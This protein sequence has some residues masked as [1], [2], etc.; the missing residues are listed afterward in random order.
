MSRSFISA[1]TPS[2]TDPA[3]LELIFVQRQ[4][5]LKQIV[6]K[7]ERSMLTAEKHHILLVGARGCGKTH[8]LTLAAD[9]LQNLAEENSSLKENMRIAWL[10]EDD[11]FTE[12][13][14][15][16]VA[17]ADALQNSYPEEFNQDYR[18]AAKGAKNNDEAASAILNALLDDL[19]APRS[20]LLMTENLDRTFNQLS[21]M[22]Q[23]TWR[24]FLQEKQ[25]IATLASAQQLVD[26]L[27]NRDE[28]FYG[29]FNIEHLSSLSADQALELIKK[30]TKV[31]ENKEL[32][33]YLEN[34]NNARYRIRALH[35]LA[36]GNQ[37]MY[38][39]L[40]ELL[41]KNALDDLVSAFEALADEL[42]P[43][44]QERL[45]SL[46]AQQ[47]KIVQYLCGVT[48]AQS[49]KTI[50]EQMFI[51]ETTCSKQLSELKNKR[52]V[53]STKQ[54]KQS[55]Y[56]MSEPLMRLC[57]DIKNQRG[58][59][60]RLITQFIR[61]WFSVE[62]LSKYS[63]QQGHVRLQQYCEV[64]LQAEP[65][66]VKPLIKDLNCLI[67]K[68]LDS[69][70]LDKAMRYVEEL[71]S[72]DKDMA[73]LRRID[74]LFEKAKSDFFNRRFDQVV[75]CLNEIIDKK[76]V[77][78]KYFALAVINRGF[79]YGKQGE[80]DLELQDYITLIEGADIPNDIVVQAL[81]NRAAVYVQKNK[82]DFAI[83]DYNK[84]FDMKDASVEQRA[85]ALLNR[86][87]AYGKQGHVDLEVLDYS[88]LIHMVDV[89][90]DYL[91]KALFNRGITYALIGQ[92]D[93]A[94]SDYNNLIRMDD[95]PKSL[96]AKLL[97]NRGAAYSHQAKIS[98][99][100]QDYT[101]LAAMKDAS[102]DQVAKALFN[103]GLT[104]S[105]QG[106][107]DLALQDYGALIAMKDAPTD[108]IVKALF[109]RSIAY[110]QRN[111]VDLALL[112]INALIDMEGVPGNILAQALYNRGVGY[113][114]SRKYFLARED[115]SAAL[116]IINIEGIH[117][118]LVLFAITEPMLIINGQE[119]FESALLHAFTE[120]DP[121]ISGYG[122]T[123]HDLLE[124]LLQLGSIQWPSYVAIIVRIYNQ[125]QQTE[126]LTNGL[127]KSIR[128]LVKS[129]LSPQ[130]LDVWLAAWQQHTQDMELFEL[131]LQILA[132]AIESIKTKDKQPLLS[133]PLEIR[134]LVLPLLGYE[135][136][137]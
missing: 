35:Y 90:K 43:Y 34:D 55:F 120:A 115:F 12:L 22:G 2:N 69:N 48:A 72:A 118:N 86:A 83:L 29:F 91:V 42:T 129:N 19:P 38:V 59:P 62:E 102:R 32:L 82:I 40:S 128:G 51:A 37:R 126:I 117:K 7:L 84:L 103:R 36:G 50:S 16:A 18:A 33:N 99:A 28:P 125:Y 88:T 87:V 130:Q 95:L 53:V 133:L 27:S 108:Q 1:Y 24:G 41:T 45:R 136:E 8:L 49:V 71:N 76:Y 9:R 131:P 100:L 109:S 111:Q 10:S 92:F 110:G 60:L 3:I 25:R 93:F 67:D 54:G 81:F 78:K 85:Q 61:A 5:L 23:R 14:D 21:E 121:N 58:K 114:F 89:P 57:L 66:Y 132:A 20:I 52:Y 63:Q 30:I 46:P 73:D 31:Q 137:Q 106:E 4:R 123:P 124:T 135:E 127:I 70:N 65:V 79:A 26:S 6:K 75:N 74:V 116:S 97:L 94:I 107:I 98:L 47:A 11:T 17:I 13:V 104:Y 119:D 39:I 77:P 56:E 112:D 15:I 64:A 80:F 122:G 101:T 68:S 113:F 105:Q 96:V 44:F 134:Q